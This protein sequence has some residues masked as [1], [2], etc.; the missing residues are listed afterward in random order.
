[1]AN[2]DEKT[3]IESDDSG[4]EEAPKATPDKTG[5]KRLFLF[6]GVGLGAVV[7]GIALTAFVIKPLMSGS[8]EEDAES[9]RVEQSQQKQ[10]V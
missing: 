8:A 9:A 10:K 4:V 3:M 2:E 1:M 6:G 5:R 7:I